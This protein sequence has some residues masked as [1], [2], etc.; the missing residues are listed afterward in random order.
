MRTLLNFT[1]ECQLIVLR[2]DAVMSV[3]FFYRSWPDQFRDPKV[4]AVFSANL[5]PDASEPHT[6]TI[7]ALTALFDNESLPPTERNGLPASDVH[8]RDRID[9]LLVSRYLHSL[10]DIATSQGPSAVEAVKLLAVIS[11]EGLMPPQELYH[12]WVSLEISTNL[13]V[14]CIATKQQQEM[15]RRYGRLLQPSA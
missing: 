10:R 7:R 3:S 14:R 12:T 8:D 6:I 15:Y 13:D 2:L 9:A 1:D 5:R 4:H 11:T